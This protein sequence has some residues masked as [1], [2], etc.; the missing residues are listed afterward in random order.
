MKKLL[1]IAIVA[2]G[3]LV[4]LFVGLTIFVKSYLSS[5]RLKPLILPKVKRQQEER[6][7]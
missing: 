7:I 5:D 4:L 2:I 6:S 3:V 1:K